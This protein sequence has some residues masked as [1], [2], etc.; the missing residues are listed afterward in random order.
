MQI[1]SSH[2]RSLSL[3]LCVALRIFAFATPSF[4]QFFLFPSS[5]LVIRALAEQLHTRTH[6]NIRGSVRRDFFSGSHG[7]SILCVLLVCL[8][9]QSG[10]P[11]CASVSFLCLP[12]TLII[13]CFLIIFRSVLSFSFFLSLHPRCHAILS[14]LFLVE[15]HDDLY[16]Y[17]HT[18]TLGRCFFPRHTYEDKRRRQRDRSR[19]NKEKSHPIFLF[20]FCFPLVL[21]PPTPHRLV[22]FLP[23]FLF[24]GEKSS[25]RK[26]EVHNTACV[27][28]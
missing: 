9:V 2:S 21:R 18:H 8:R 23:F 16:K 22:I 5:R 15:Q 14:P 19:E 3:C 20:S 25:W 13:Y 6:T 1:H 4:G 17:T 27:Q 10:L 28:R 7:P 26:R 12:R 24:R 11:A